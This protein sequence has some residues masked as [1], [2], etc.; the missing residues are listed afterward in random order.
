VDGSHRSVR[1]LGSPAEANELFLRQ[2][3]ELPAAC[4]LFMDVH[5]STSHLQAVGDREVQRAFGAL[6]EESEPF[7]MGRDGYL[8]DVSGDGAILLFT[9]AHRF[10]HAVAAA[11]T[12]QSIA[13][14]VVGAD[15]KRETGRDFAIGIGLEQGNVTV[16]RVAPARWTWMCVV[17]NTSAKLADAAPKG[18]VYATHEVFRSLTPTADFAVAWQQAPV[19]LKIGEVDKLVNIGEV[20][21]DR[22]AGRQSSVPAG[23][24]DDPSVRRD[25]DGEQAAQRRPC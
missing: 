25:G 12:I 14:D 7:F 22:T 5:G 19:T 23:L 24:A 11:S 18:S 16:Q 8:A 20:S 6:I 10:D 4:S 9:G 15:F 17:T 2:T 1:R 21:R 3:G 13:I